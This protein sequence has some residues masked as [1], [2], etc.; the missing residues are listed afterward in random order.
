MKKALPFAALSAAFALSACISNG[1]ALDARRFNSPDFGDS[2][3]SNIA[4]E[5]IPADPAAVNSPVEG[6]GARQSLAQQRYHNDKVKTPPDPTTSE[7]GGS[8]NN[9]GSGGAGAGSTGGPGSY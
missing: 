2:V 9:N 5:S 7:V 6:D 1:G 8:T 3:R 4:A